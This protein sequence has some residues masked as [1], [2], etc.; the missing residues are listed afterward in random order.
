MFVTLSD[1]V[2]PF[3]ALCLISD[4]LSK[5]KIRKLSIGPLVAEAILS[6]H[7]YTSVS[8]VLTPDNVA[9]RSRSEA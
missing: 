9:D 8:S 4:A 7:D 3:V 2:P 1:A 5:P 6:I